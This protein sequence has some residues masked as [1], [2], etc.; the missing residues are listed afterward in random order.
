MAGMFMESLGA[1]D[2]LG[3]SYGGLLAQRLALTALARI[4]RLVIASS[5]IYPVPADAYEGWAERD[6]RRAA[7]TQ[8][9]SDPGL[10]GADLVRAA[11][12]AQARAGRWRADRLPRRLTRR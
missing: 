3:F 10:S 2:V 11:A 4:S 12:I 5:S 8:V 1:V 6:A 7:V 9:W